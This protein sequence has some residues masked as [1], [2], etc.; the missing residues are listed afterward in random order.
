MVF[1]TVV[2]INHESRAHKRFM[3]N[4]SNTIDERKLGT[5]KFM[6]ACAV[7]NA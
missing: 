7:P 3:G 4:Y 1:V 5:S 2:Q 6:D